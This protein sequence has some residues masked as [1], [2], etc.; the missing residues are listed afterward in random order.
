LLYAIIWLYIILLASILIINNVL[1]KRIWKPFYSILDRLKSFAVEHAADLPAPRTNVTE[2][3]MLHETISSL[4]QRTVATFNSQKQFIENASH[5]LQTPLAI[6]INKLELMAEKNTLSEAQLNELSSVMQ[7]LERLTRLNKTLLLLSK[8]E[9]RQFSD[10]T[11][12][13][14]NVLADHLAA[15]FADFAEF[16]KVKITAL[17]EHILVQQVNPEL[18]T[19]MIS[20]L[21]KNA[22]VHNIE[23]G[24]VQIK[25]TSSGFAVE[26]TSYAPALNEHRIFERF[27]KDADATTSTGLGLAIVKSVADY[28]NLKIKYTYNNRHIFTVTFAGNVE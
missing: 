14:F 4:L 16:K 20:N 13:N 5:E 23:G 22:I 1:L 3:N 25:I 24:S 8:I 27:Y 11:T 26:N 6:S 12:V 19:I 2:F 9:N 18:A 28:Y 10:S 21:L 7:T 15:E 17:H